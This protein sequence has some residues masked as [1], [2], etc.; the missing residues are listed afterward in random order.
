MKFSTK[1]AICVLF[2]CLFFVGCAHVWKLNRDTKKWV[3]MPISQVILSWG[4]PQ[5]VYDLDGTKSMT[6]IK[7]KCEVVFGVDTGGHVVA[8]NWRG[9]KYDCK[10]LVRPPSDAG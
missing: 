1:P 9:S 6:Y 10:N 2:S 7:G 5:K 4:E 8:A 3:G